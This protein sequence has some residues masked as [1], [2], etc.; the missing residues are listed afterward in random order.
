MKEVYYPGCKIKGGY[1]ETSQRIT[2]YLKK[3][4][5][6]E[7]AGCCK[8]DYGMMEDGD[9]AVLICN[10]CVKD[11]TANTG[12]VPIHFVYE[13][14]DED[15]QFQYPDRTGEEWIIQDCGHGYQ[16]HNMEGTV[17][18]LLQK[19]HAAYQELPDERKV[20]DG[21]RAQ[22]HISTVQNNE[23]LFRK[24]H[25]VTYCGICNRYLLNDGIDAHMLAELLFSE[26]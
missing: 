1:P 8:Q 5:H 14:I 17:R 25:V 26:N 22:E 12:E 19:M 20:K 3:N 10:N 7:P 9:T 24:K 16:G 23:E 15:T 13:I 21:M 6:L 2:A 18:S 11:L 4:R